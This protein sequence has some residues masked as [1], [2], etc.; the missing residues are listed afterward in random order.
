MNFLCV[1]KSTCDRRAASLLA[2]HRSCGAANDAIPVE[3]VTRRN[4]ARPFRD[5]EPTCFWA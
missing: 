5:T 4:Q 3:F 1:P 2:F